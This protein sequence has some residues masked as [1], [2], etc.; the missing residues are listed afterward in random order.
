MNY[1][2]TRFRQDVARPSR[3]WPRAATGGWA[4]WSCYTAVRRA[5]P[6]HLTL[7]M[8]GSFLICITRQLSARSLYDRLLAESERRKEEDYCKPD[9]QHAVFARRHIIFD[10]L[11]DSRCVDD[12]A[13]LQ[14]PAEVDDEHETISAIVLIISYWQYKCLKRTCLLPSRPTNRLTVR[15]LVGG[16]PCKDL[17][18]TMLESTEGLTDR[19]ASTVHIIPT[20]SLMNN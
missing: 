19:R 13:K 16:S 1:L 20:N 18:R 9:W 7:P 11:A 6:H 14:N 4:G 8:P 17:M 5:A 2:P 10:S 3:S 12:A 15:D